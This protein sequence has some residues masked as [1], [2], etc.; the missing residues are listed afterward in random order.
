MKNDLFATHIASHKKFIFS[1][2]YLHGIFWQMSDMNATPQFGTAEYAAPAGSDRCVACKQPVT[3]RYYRI[4]G[5][6]ACESCKERLQRE[7]P[8]DSHAN[9]V[10][11]LL[12]GVGAAIVGMILYAAIVVTMDFSIGYFALAVGWL[13]GKAIMMGSR[14]F[15]GRRYQIAALLLTYSAIS[16]AAVPIALSYRIKAKRAA[17]ELQKRLVTPTPPQSGD[18][19]AGQEAPAS[20]QTT[21]PGE[22]PAVDAKASQAVGLGVVLGRLLLVGLASPFLELRDPLHGILGLIILLVG[23]GIAWRITQGSPKVDIQ[24]PYD[25]APAPPVMR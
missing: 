15:G 17:Q 1:P 2:S 3:E 6:M 8:Q 5:N 10:R 24:G 13:V 21:Q 20:G 12:F 9:Y 19:S 7:M 25:S 11:G 14:G 22:Q 18:P 16:V 23:I 4:N